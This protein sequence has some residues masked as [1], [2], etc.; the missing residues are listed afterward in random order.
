MDAAA[1]LIDQAVSLDPQSA[2]VGVAKA[3]CWQTKREYDLARK[4]TGRAYLRWMPITHWPGALLGDLES[5]D[6]NLA[7]AEAAYT[8]AMKTAQNNLADLLKRAGVRIQQKKYEEAQK[9]IDVLKKRVPRNA[10]VNF[11]QG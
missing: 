1:E 2:Y 5:Q 11:T 8:K 7:K 9:D 4:D 3:V 6:R 10:G